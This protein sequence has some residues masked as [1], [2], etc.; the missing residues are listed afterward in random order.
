MTN[1]INLFAL[2]AV[3]AA[4]TFSS[5]KKE[6]GSMAPSQSSTSS[7]DFSENGTN[8]DEIAINN[9]NAERS[10]HH[11]KLYIVGNEQGVNNIHIYDIHSNGSLSHAG[12]VASGGP[13]AGAP[14]GSQGAL[15]FSHNYKWLFAVNAGD[16]SVS[17]F[18]VNHDGS[19]TLAHTVNSGGMMP[20][21]VTCHGH[22]LYVV[23]F[24]SANICGF[25]VGAGG[26]MTMI[27]G[28]NQ[29]LSAS[30]AGP[31]QI[32][33][34][35]GG[36][37]LIVTEK[38]TNVVN[39]FDLDADGAAGLGNANPSTGYTPFGFCF[40]RGHI[41][42]SNAEMGAPNASTC[43]SYDLQG[44]MV[45]P[46]NGAVPSGETAACWVTET[47]YQRFVYVTNTGSNSISSYYVSPWGAI[48]L[49]HA[50]AAPGNAPLDIIVAPNNYY[51]YAINSGN[52]TI[53]GYHRAF[54]GDLDHIGDTPGLPDFA[55]GIVTR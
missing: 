20:V 12:T 43:T 18:E 28:S 17:S 10:S 1:K 33:F 6:E 51:V 36:G 8:P 22:K 27:P 54:L 41:I 53:G 4:L 52:H 21:S 38:M 9:P 26:T 42:T 39:V 5:C 16:N 15:A 47:K 35:P 14:L 37:K 34:T 49:V 48:Y 7:P 11:S 55:A 3:S 32:S 40:A 23:N 24:T 29:A 44:M 2:V 13:G 25:M 19:L 46:V 30:N 45:N 50:D 31:A